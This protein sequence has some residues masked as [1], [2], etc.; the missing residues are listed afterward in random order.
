MTATVIPFGARSL[1]DA[2]AEADMEIA[3]LED[4]EA[5]QH[6]AWQQTATE[7]EHALKERDTLR[8]RMALAFC[9]TCQ[10]WH[11][12]LSE[13]CP[14]PAGCADCDAGPGEPCA[15]GCLSR[16]EISYGD[17]ES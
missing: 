1:A 15:P 2:V 16:N 5:R 12:P 3:V 17:G 8:A 13:P 9:D 6:A 4:L 11:V 10:N 7:L 14:P